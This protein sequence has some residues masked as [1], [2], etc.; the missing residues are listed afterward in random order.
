MRDDE[1]WLVDR[2]I[3]KQDEIEIEAARSIRIRTL[4]SSFFLDGEQ[5]LEERARRHRRLAHYRGVQVERLRPRGA[6]GDGVVEAG[7]AK[8]SEQIPKA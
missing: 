8:T 2:E 5:R 3:S 6:D 1:T 7:N 4:A